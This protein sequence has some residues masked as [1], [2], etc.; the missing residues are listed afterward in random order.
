MARATWGAQV[1]RARRILAAGA[2]VAIAAVPV[3]SASAAERHASRLFTS[4]SSITSVGPWMVVA[5]R[6][7]SSLTVLAASSGTLLR[8]VAGTA[9][10]VG[11]P[12]SLASATAGGR[13]LAL[14]AGTGGRVAELALEA[15]GASV[16]V[17]PI[18]L[19]RPVGCGAGAAYLAVA[20]ADVVDACADG[21]V[22]VWAIASGALVRS[23]RATVT[24]VTHA[25]GV[26]VL[27][28]T[29]DVT[30]AATGAGSAP[31]GVAQLSV[32]TGARLRTVT[33]AQD[34]AYGFASPAGIAS[35]GTDVWEINASGNT[36]DELSGST[37]R[38]IASSSTNLYDPGVVAATPT[39]VWVSS[40]TWQG[41][42][43]MV[44][45]FKVVN[46]ALQSPWMMCNSNGPYQFA[47]P[48]GFALHGSTLW[49][50]NA[51]NGVV[52]EM[53]ASTGALIAT[54]T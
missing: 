47:D 37:L 30:N 54:Y 14:V 45:Q 18:H 3:A 29:I 38:F 41:S 27:G 39:T 20:R 12:T 34:A 32:A 11:T 15:R 25:T 48:T 9:V 4:P 51:T 46:R 5:N 7:P 6:V 26:A 8:R 53:S 17:T 1:T 50:A 31:D 52:D 35:D 49:V 42:S 28:S 21:V 13:R 44:T 16:A 36:V 10:G 2:A 22:S 43:S 33:D 40:S 23:I 24:G 19:L